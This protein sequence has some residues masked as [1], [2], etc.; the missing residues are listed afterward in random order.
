MLV[1]LTVLGK[2]VIGHHVLVTF[3]NLRE[4]LQDLGS[5]LHMHSCCS[6]ERRQS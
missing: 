5:A 6:L 2:V 4:N 1:H 3:E